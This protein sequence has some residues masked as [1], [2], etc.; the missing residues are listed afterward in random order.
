MYNNTD[1]SSQKRLTNDV[2]VQPITHHFLYK[3]RVELL[4]YEVLLIPNINVNNIK[5][6]GSLITKNSNKPDLS[7]KSARCPDMTR[8]VLVQKVFSGHLTH[9]HITCAGKNT[10][11]ANT[12]FC[13]YMH[14]SASLIKFDWPGFKLAHFMLF[15]FR[16]VHLICYYFFVCV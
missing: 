12:P 15:C 13:L 10:F 2:I 8:D 14:W 5:V 16:S 7:T 4:Y 6:K 3:D 1:N 9:L 11:C